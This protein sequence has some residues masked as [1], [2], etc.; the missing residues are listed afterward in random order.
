MK[1]S[2]NHLG[3]LAIIETDKREI[4]GE[5]EKR[6]AEIEALRDE[7]SDLVME[8][9]AFPCE[10]DAESMD[11]AE[12]AE[13]VDHLIDEEDRHLL[14]DEEPAC[15]HCFAKGTPTEENAAVRRCLQCRTLYTVPGEGITFEQVLTFVAMREPMTLSQSYRRSDAFQFNLQVSDLA[16]VN[17]ADSERVPAY[18]EG[19]LSGVAMNDSKRVVR[20]N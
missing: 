9:A 8:A 18:H 19:R 2:T 12:L 6:K 11:F 1:R 4:R 10:E 3:L 17:E 14:D 20:W 5:I 13:T 15:P 7:I 16:E